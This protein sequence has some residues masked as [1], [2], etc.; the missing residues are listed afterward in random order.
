M[1]QRDGHLEGLRYRPNVWRCLSDRLL[2]EAW[3][4][5]LQICD[6]LNPKELGLDLVN[7]PLEA[8]YNVTL[9]PTAID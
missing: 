6:G 9:E 5:R 1:W 3:L 8:G 7:V 2:L 4:R